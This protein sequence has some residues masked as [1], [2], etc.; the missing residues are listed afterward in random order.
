MRIAA[1]SILAL[2]ALTGCISLTADLP[3]EMIRHAARED[4]AD[5]GASCSQDGN[6]FSEGAL[7]CMAGQRMVCD[8]TG[9]WIKD[10][11]C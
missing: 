10:G 4:G 9:R 8:P 2:V 5:I 6:R 3:E 7:V 11:E 1:L